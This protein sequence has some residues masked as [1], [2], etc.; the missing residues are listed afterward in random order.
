MVRWSWQPQA[1]LSVSGFPIACRRRGQ[2][3]LLGQLR[4]VAWGHHEG[5]STDAA[6]ASSEVLPATCLW[7]GTISGL[8]FCQVF[9]DLSNSKIYCF[10]SWHSGTY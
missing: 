9:S 10:E 1:M 8:P 3:G 7:L 6:C 2:G 5:F 4:A